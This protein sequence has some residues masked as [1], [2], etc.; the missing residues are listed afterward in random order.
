MLVAA[1]SSDATNAF[2]YTKSL[3]AAARIVIS[4]VLSSAVCKANL[5]IN[6]DADAVAVIAICIPIVLFRYP[7]HFYV[8][9]YP[10]IPPFQL[11]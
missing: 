2:T 11:L 5:R 1:A 10:A 3:F 7:C 4:D 8:L 6:A 9:T